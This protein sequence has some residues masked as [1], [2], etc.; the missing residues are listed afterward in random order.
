MRG[1]PKRARPLNHRVVAVK[2]SRR[3]VRGNKSASEGKKLEGFYFSRQQARGRPTSGLLLA[4]CGRREGRPLKSR[5]VK[6]PLI[7]QTDSGESGSQRL[8]PPQPRWLAQGRASNSRPW[9]RL[10]YYQQR[11]RPSHQHQN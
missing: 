2:R 6:Q 1:L 8:A 7:K 10:R 9:T 11:R 4:R 5:K 3:G